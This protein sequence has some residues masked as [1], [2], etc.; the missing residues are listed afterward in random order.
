M[1]EKIQHFDDLES[2]INFALSI[3]ERNYYFFKYWAEKVNRKSIRD[4]LL[5]WAEE[6]LKHKEVLLKI[7]HDE[8]FDD[9]SIEVPD[10]K[11]SDYFKDAE[12]SEDMTYEEALRIAMKR[13]NVEIETYEYLAEISRS[14]RVKKMLLNLAADSRQRKLDFEKKY[15]ER[16]M[17]EN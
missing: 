16:F 4:A 2:A 14:P 13:E 12:P 15:I 5:D 11:L 1:A 10:L 7:E 8:E 3:I 17:S 9:L 6:E